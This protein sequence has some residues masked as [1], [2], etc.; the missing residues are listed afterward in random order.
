MGDAAAEQ[1]GEEVE[2]LRASRARLVATAD[3]ER[4]ELER[5]I[6]DGVQQQLV[7]HAVR[8]QLLGQACEAD[9]AASAL[10]E[11]I[12]GDLR[13]A[14]A[15]VRRL[16]ERTYPLVLGARGLAVALRAAAGNAGIPV[17][18]VVEAE[19]AWSADVTAAV[20]RCCLAALENVAAHA[21]P[22]ARATIAIRD[23]DGALVFEV[24]DDGVG[25]P[26]ETPA[27]TG[28]DLIETRVAA[29]GGRLAV[30]S[31]PGGGTRVVGTIPPDEPRPGEPQSTSAR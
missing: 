27:G 12:R 29:L 5:D 21:G 16:C 19:D 10:L 18:V 2:R 6:H 22:G 1:L 17:R 13:D 30:V 31:G 20:Y 11:E 26:A 4:R 15:E 9:P 24:A 25:F 8:L 23:E 3:A 7:A 28:L 14:L